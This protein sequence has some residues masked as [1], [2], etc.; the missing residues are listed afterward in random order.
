[1]NRDLSQQITDRILHLMQ[2]AGANWKQEWVGSGKHINVVT[3][4]PYRGIN[5]VILALL[6]GGS[7]IHGTYK[8]WVDL[9]AQVRKG[10]KATHIFFYKPYA[11]RDRETDEQKQIMLAKTYAVFGIH[12]VDNAPDIKIEQ[13]PEIE[14]HA[15]CDRLIAE[16]G[17]P[18]HYGSDRAFYSPTKDEITLPAPSQFDNREAFYSTAFHEISHATGHPSRLNR[19]M[20]G[21]FGDS[22]YSFE[23]LIAESAAALVC[24]SAGIIPEPRRETAQYLNNWMHGLRDDKQAIVRAFSHAQR[25]ADFILKETPAHEPQPA[26]PAPED[27]ARPFTINLNAALNLGGGL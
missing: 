18:I 26:R 19:E 6:G 2:T 3:K 23:E 24:V 12:Q 16:C 14:R 27:P 9:G 13:R 21:R 8:Q 5:P 10:E 4:K 7:E 15:E 25:A 17:V 20:K 22:K 1:M 11:V